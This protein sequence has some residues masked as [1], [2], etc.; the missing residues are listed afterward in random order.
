MGQFILVIK[1]I[2]RNVPLPNMLHVD[3]FKSSH[4]AATVS[5]K[6]ENVKYVHTV[7]EGV[8]NS[9]EWQLETII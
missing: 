6:C 7:S 2:E 3:W 5:R 1:T 4:M 9:T 8:D